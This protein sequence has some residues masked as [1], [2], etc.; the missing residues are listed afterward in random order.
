MTTTS[1]IISLAL[2]LFFCHLI[3]LSAQPPPFTYHNCSLSKG[4][5]I[6]SSA[7]ETNLNTLLSRFTP[8]T[9]I[10][11]G[12]YTSSFGE[13]P[14]K[15]HAQ[16]LCRGDV[17]PYSCRKCLN[18]AKTLLPKLCPYQKDAFGYYE[19]CTFQYSSRSLLGI[20][21]FPDFSYG[22]NNPED[23]KD[24]ESYTKALNDLMISLKTKAAAGDST[25]KLAVGYKEA[26][27][28]EIVYGL[29]Q[30]SPDLSRRDCD[31]CLVKAISKIPD[32]CENKIGGRVI[33]FSCNLRFERVHFYYD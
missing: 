1:C 31:V 17:E 19:F 25:F 13:S 21:R 18:D 7:Y 5:Y 22:F 6:K 4:T 2:V 30:C 9:V 23:A 32:C 3:I 33:K 10:D 26:D 15:V 20:Y 29:A 14:N 28:S 11:Y 16:G 24:G 12:F 27:E 8:D